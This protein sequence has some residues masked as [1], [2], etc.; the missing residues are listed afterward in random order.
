MAIS[1]GGS[2]IK[3]KLTKAEEEI[4][5]LLALG[6]GGAYIAEELLISEKTVRKHLEHIYLKLN[7]HS[8]TEAVAWAWMNGLAK[9]HPLFP[10]NGMSAGCSLRNKDA[11]QNK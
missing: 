4:L 3:L 10:Q 6:W 5:R 2:A 7:I 8:R 11:E 1:A 9:K